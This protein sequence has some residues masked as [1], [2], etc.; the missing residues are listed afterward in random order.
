MSLILRNKGKKKAVLRRKKNG[1]EGTFS[2]DD[3]KYNVELELLIK[4]KKENKIHQSTFEDDE[5]KQ[6]DLRM[7]KQSSKQSI[8]NTNDNIIENSV[9]PNSVESIL[10]SRP[11]TPTKL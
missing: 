7:E 6:F 3:D 10:S 9:I 2:T 5:S 8:L 11:S 1:R 4:K